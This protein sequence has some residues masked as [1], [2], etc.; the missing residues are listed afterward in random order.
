M[1][2]KNGDTEKKSDIIKMMCIEL[3]V[4]TKKQLY[5]RENEL[6]EIIRF[7][8]SANGAAFTIQCRTK[9][10]IDFA[11]SY[12]QRFLEI[13]ERIQQLLLV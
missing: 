8:N 1:V 9:Q 3:H 4:D 12:Q 13:C 11:I 2:W 5:I 6:F 10:L 7:L